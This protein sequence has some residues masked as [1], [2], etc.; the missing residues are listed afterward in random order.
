MEIT[1]TTMI[2][3]IFLL[4]QKRKIM[5]NRKQFQ[6]FRLKGLLKEDWKKAKGDN[7]IDDYEYKKSKLIEYWKSTEMEIDENGNMSYNGLDF[8]NIDKVDIIENYKALIE[9]REK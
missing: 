8:G 1:I 2:F 9:K 5:K 7:V 4:V 6:C 3:N